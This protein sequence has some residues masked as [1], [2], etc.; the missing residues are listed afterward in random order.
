MSRAC[1]TK[2][3]GSIFV[4]LRNEATKNPP[5]KKILHFVQND[6]ERFRMQ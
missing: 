6:S 1:R 5:Q 3:T 4:I 2:S